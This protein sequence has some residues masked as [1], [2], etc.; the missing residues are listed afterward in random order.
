[1]QKTAIE[2]EGLEDRIALDDVES[3]EFLNLPTRQLQVLALLVLRQNPFGQ[4][5]GAFG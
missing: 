5:A 4:G 3:P 2:D 1:M